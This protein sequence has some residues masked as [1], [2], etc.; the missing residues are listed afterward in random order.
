MNKNVGAQRMLKPI[1]IQAESALTFFEHQHTEVSGKKNKIINYKI[2]DYLSYQCAG[3][4]CFH[5]AETIPYKRIFFSNQPV[6]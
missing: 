3:R 5:K 1:L 6:T 4:F 2:Q